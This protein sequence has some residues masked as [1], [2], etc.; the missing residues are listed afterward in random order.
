MVERAAVDLPPSSG[1][2]KGKASRN[3][4]N[5][6]ELGSSSAAVEAA[7]AAAMPWT[8][9][10]PNP[11][12][13]LLGGSPVAAVPLA[14]VPPAP[15]EYPAD[16]RERDILLVRLLQS[17]A[18]AIACG[19]FHLINRGLGWVADLA[20]PDG[21]SLQRLA[22]AFAEAFALAFVLPCDGVCRVLQLPQAAPPGGVAAARQRFRAMCPFVRLAGAA[23]NLSVVE[24]MENEGRVVH[25]VDLGGADTNQWVELV[26]LFA[27]RSGGPPRMLRLTVVNEAE[28][29]L[30]A[31]AMYLNAEA[32]RLDVTFQFHPVQSSIDALTGVGPLGVIAGQALA[33]VATLQIHRLLAYEITTPFYPIDG[34]GKRPAAAEQS[35]QHTITTR[36]D[37]L[38][39]TIRGLSPKLM[40]LTEQEADLNVAE[41]QPRVWSAL[42]YY[43]ALFDAVE[44]SAPLVS[45]LDRACVERWLLGE[46]I[47]D[48]VTCK[49]TARW[50][51]HEKLERWAARMVAAGFAPADQLNQGKSIPVSLSCIASHMEIHSDGCQNF[52]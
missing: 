44:E 27:A 2:D 48:I 8:G 50:E 17:T 52:E 34:N 7:A 35:T 19:M 39:R 42:N 33:V 4:R 11:Y 26:R 46:E 31:T 13:L 47:R 20:S 16:E 37:A 40:I 28:D 22:S 49:G 38:L 24:A 5:R 43:A 29:F 12:A 15:V 6:P 25:V 41:L 9:N 1:R 32:Q 30:S 14:A 3:K 18:D 36:A 45:P 23:A 21:R 10:Q 51:R